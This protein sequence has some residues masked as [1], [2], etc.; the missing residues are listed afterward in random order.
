MGASNAL[1]LKMIALQA[2]IVGLIGYGLGVGVA[3]FTSFL[4]KRSELAFRMPWQLLIV[5]FLAVTLICIL[6]AVLSMR[7]VAKLEPAIVFK[8]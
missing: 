5:S 6:A 2:T 3:S 7:K 8:S 4:S 1:L